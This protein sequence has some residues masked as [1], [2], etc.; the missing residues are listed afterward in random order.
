MFNLQDDDSLRKESFDSDDN[1]KAGIFPSDNL[2]TS[3]SD[4]LTKIVMLEE[5]IRTLKEELIVTK[6][7]SNFHRTNCLRLEQQVQHLK[8]N[9]PGEVRARGISTPSRKIDTASIISRYTVPKLDASI[10]TSD[11]ILFYGLCYVGFGEERQ[12][13]VMTTSVDRF[14]A[15]Y[16]PEPRSVKDLMSDLCQE[17]PDTS[18]KEL[19]MGLN[20]LKLYD[21]ESVL[22]ARWNYD[23]SKCSDKCHK[24]TRRIDSF[25][26]RLIIFD[27]SKFTPD[28]VHIISVDGVNF[29]TQEFR[30]DPG[31]KWF[32]HK[33]HSSGLKYEF[34]LSLWENHCVWIN[35]PD[36]AGLRHD[37]AVFCGAMNMKDPPETWD[38]DALLFQIPDGKRAIGDSAYEGLPEKVTVKR[39][40]H[41]QDVFRFLDRAQNRQEAYHARLENY[42]I[43]YHRFRHGKNTEDKMKLHKMVVGAVAV[44]VEYDMKYHPLFR[45]C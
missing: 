22:V 28:Q 1:S 13:V 16:G 6:N 23:E 40:G 7:E 32:D 43:L 19:L 30:G 36:P 3:F 33:S 38:R 8:Q 17:F 44:I 39:P 10:L 35:G 21:I 24:T 26:E 29:I 37:K 41:S 9:M 31:T 4:A 15:H 25:R 20:W 14:K 27:T 42:N 12:R 45:V 34:A 2:I 18:F 5:E 11:D